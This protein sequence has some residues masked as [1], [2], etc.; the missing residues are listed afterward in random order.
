MEN[1]VTCGSGYWG[2]FKMPTRD[3]DVHVE[4]SLLLYSFRSTRGWFRGAVDV[5]TTA[6]DVRPIYA[7]KTGTFDGIGVRHQDTPF[8][9]EQDA[10]TRIF[11]SRSGESTFRPPCSLLRIIAHTITAHDGRRRFLHHRVLLMFGV[12]TGPPCYSSQVFQAR[13]TRAFVGL[14]SV[15]A[16]AVACGT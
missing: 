7:R 15:Y 4:E 8:L 2:L 9:N 12:P 14:G 1:Y 13:P 6:C 11:T 3:I 10:R 5:D 16:A